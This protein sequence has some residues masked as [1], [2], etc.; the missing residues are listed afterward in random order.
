MAS[1]RI[2]KVTHKNDLS[3]QLTIFRLEPERIQT[4][5]TQPSKDMGN[6]LLGAQR[7]Q[8]LPPL[9]PPGQRQGA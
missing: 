3:P 4:Y 7:F 1:R 5:V 8:D 2:G 6:N 9:E